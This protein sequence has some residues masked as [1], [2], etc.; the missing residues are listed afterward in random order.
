MSQGHFLQ[1]TKEETSILLNYKEKGRL[2]VT[3]HYTLTVD[4]N[5]V[6]GHVAKSSY[7]RL[8]YIFMIV[9]MMVGV[10]DDVM[11]KCFISLWLLCDYRVNNFFNYTI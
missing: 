1:R 11:L 6:N 3:D 7:P 8:N 4:C 5:T 2:S 10:I 9:S